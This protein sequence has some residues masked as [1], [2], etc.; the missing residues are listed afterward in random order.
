MHTYM[1]H[2]TTSRH[3]TWEPGDATRYAVT[4]LYIA[5]QR[6][7]EMITVLVDSPSGV[8]RPVSLMHTYGPLPEGIVANTF[9]I[10]N[11]QT[12]THITALLC[13][14]LGREAIP[15]EGAYY[16]LGDLQAR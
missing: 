10:D 1:T 12:V 9:L 6:A 15:G 4:V 14:M 3:G 2:L 16:A 8:A 5:P 13:E 7:E 11:P